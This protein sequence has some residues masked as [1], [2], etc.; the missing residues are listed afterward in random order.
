MKAWLK[1]L[2]PATLVAGFLCSYSWL[3]LHYRVWPD[4]CFF[5][6]L[7]H[8]L[9]VAK[10]YSLCYSLLNGRW[11]GN[12]LA[13]GIFY[14]AGHNFTLYAIFLSLFTLGFVGAAAFLFRS[15]SL[16]FRRQQISKAAAFFFG[17]V[18]TSVVYFMQYPG[19]AETWG[20]LDSA[21][22]HML[23]V[24]LSMLLTGMLIDE[25]SPK[26]RPAI[27][28]LSLAL[29]GMNE[30]NAV[31][32]ALLLSGLYLS[33]N[34]YRRARLSRLSFVIAIVGIGGSLLIN[35][36]SAGFTTR[37]NGMPDLD[38]V[39]ALKNTV[40][41]FLLPF[42]QPEPVSLAVILGL[43]LLTAL[44]LRTEEGRYMLRDI[45]VRKALVF[46]AGLLFMSVFLH[47]HILSDII[48]PRGALWPYT[49]LLFVLSFPITA[50]LLTFYKA[51]P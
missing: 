12:A 25:S 21:T 3:L 49:L 1:Y 6:G 33:R 23:S 29:G 5:D 44:A 7:T 18:F 37:M 28:L 11:V 13:C 32:S 20:W 17:I 27:L 14:V 30:V 45:Q 34:A 48:P 16:T 46:A 43:L 15:Y 2:I 24:T 47:C 9:G 8:K 36:L 4:D 10:T 38:L 19:R 51:A 22:V 26:N 42:M 39:Q 35:Y 41:S 40:H 50:S 31:C